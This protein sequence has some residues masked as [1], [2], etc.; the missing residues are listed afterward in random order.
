MTEP[1]HGAA[2][3]GAKR[4]F[5]TF[6]MG[7]RLYAIAAEQVSEVMHVPPVA[8][9]PQAPRGLLGL[10]NL[11]GAVLPIASLRGLLGE[12]EIGKAPGARAIVLATASPVG[13]A[14]DSVDA[15][16]TVHAAAIETRQTVLAAE[17]QERLSGAFKP[18]GRADVAKILDLQSLLDSAFV[19]RAR[20]SRAATVSPDGA[21]TDDPPEAAD[22][23]RK[24]ITFDVA[25][26]EFALDL[27][28]V[29]E[30]V[31]TTA[32]L[33]GV[34]RS[35]ALVRGVMAYRDTLLPL[36]SLRGLL[37][38]GPEAGGDAGREKVVVAAVGGV[39]VGLVADR[40]RAIVSAHPDLIEATPPMLAAR[41]GG[42][43]Q[44]AA[45]YRGEGGARLISILDPN[46]LFREDVMAKLGE[47][48]QGGATAAPA[49]Q[50]AGEEAAFLVFQLGDDEFALPIA[51]VDEV[52]RVPDKIT[53]LPRTPA[54]L[55]GVVNLR[56]DVLPV[57]DQRRR[58]DM[59]PAGN[60]DGRRLIVVRTERHRAGLIVDGVSEV[61]RNTGAVEPAP[62]LAGQ[63]TRLVQGVVNLERAGRMVMLLDPAE[64]LSRTERGLL[65]AFQNR[66]AKAG[67]GRADA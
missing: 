9:V 1:G 18:D 40:M 34:P 30:I 19:Q 3:D 5:L 16:V 44:I 26:Q 24:L 20:P 52:A 58:F 61:L 63:P 64:L 62:D 41:T 8:R 15:L 23:R 25:G 42:E 14:V 46:Q 48:G 22:D 45:I 11:R 59:P 47:A 13:V 66:A 43:A 56:G 38:F 51:V 57:V 37:G 7:E 67:A 17:P 49:P 50:G 6:R 12:P 29:R 65:D 60:P 54:F 4:R 10:A 35:E 32:T 39:L 33:A 2:V 53:R 31:P 21:A 36:L 27:E 28:A 55:E